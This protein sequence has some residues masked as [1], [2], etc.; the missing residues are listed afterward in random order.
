M[1]EK[2]SARISKHAGSMSDAALPISKAR[3]QTSRLNRTR[4]LQPLM[5]QTFNSALVVSCWCS[6]RLFD[7]GLPPEAA[8]ARQRTDRCGTRLCA[9]TQHDGRC[10]LYRPI[11]RRCFGQRRQRSLH[12]AVLSP[13]GCPPWVTSGPHG[14]E[15]ACRLSAN[16]SHQLRSHSKAPASAN[17]PDG[18]ELLVYFDGL[19]PGW[20]GS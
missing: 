12:L 3:G 14:D 11:R 16:S 10:V 8:G 7:V 15:R 17:S 13:S 6:R 20:D 2:G 19:P 5:V 9:R 4:S 18:L 1:S